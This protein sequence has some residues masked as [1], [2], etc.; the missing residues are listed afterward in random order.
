MSIQTLTANWKSTVSGVLTVTLSTT[1]ALLT[2]PPVA[3]HTKLVLFLGG[4]QVV[5]KVWIALIQK[6]P[7]E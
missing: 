4:F 3:A 2:Y 5:G 6:D 7:K 1:A